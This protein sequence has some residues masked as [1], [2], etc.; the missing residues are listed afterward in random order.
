MPRPNFPRD[1]GIKGFCFLLIN[2]NDLALTNDLR[3]FAL[4]AKSF[5]ASFSVLDKP[6]VISPRLVSPVICDTRALP[7]KSARSFSSF[8]LRFSFL[9]LPWKSNM[10]NFLTLKGFG[11]IM[12]S[13]LTDTDLGDMERGDNGLGEIELRDNGLDNSGLVD[14]GLIGDLPDGDRGDLADLDSADLENAD[15]GEGLPDKAELGLALGSSADLADL[16]DA[17]AESNGDL[18]DNALVRLDADLAETCADLNDCLLEI[19]VG[20][21]ERSLSK[22]SFGIKPDVF[23]ETIASGGNII[24]NTFDSRL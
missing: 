10:G 4:N 14:F 13:G 16:A 3:P 8:S 18:P 11:V 24:S 2:E 12:L 20:N 9:V 6:Y 23:C 1:S 21:G 7:K 19:L 22:F 17:R 15:R 5:L